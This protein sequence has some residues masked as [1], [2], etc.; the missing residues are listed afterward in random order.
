MPSGFVSTSFPA[1]LY[2][3]KFPIPMTEINVGKIL[4]SIEFLN[5]SLQ[6]GLYDYSI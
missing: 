2:L 1:P 6:M 3:A 5:F 4:C